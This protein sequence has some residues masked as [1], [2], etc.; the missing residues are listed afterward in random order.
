M[1]PNPVLNRTVAPLTP[2]SFQ[3][4]SNSRSFS[5]CR[6]DHHFSFKA[7]VVKQLRGLLAV[8]GAFAS[9]APHFPK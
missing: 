7:Q 4:S 1:R 6:R 9:R 5:E 3:A 2:A 8:E